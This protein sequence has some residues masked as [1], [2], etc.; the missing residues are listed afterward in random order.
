MI[1]FEAEQHEK[2]EKSLLELF[3]VGGE[4]FFFSAISM[5]AD[6]VAV[7]RRDFCK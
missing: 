6:A 1:Y 5:M 3:F 4:K 2:E 7:T